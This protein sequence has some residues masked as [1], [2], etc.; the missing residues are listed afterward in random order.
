M[1]F[2]LDGTLANTIPMCIHAY[3]QTFEQLLGRPVLDE[4]ITVHFGLSDEG[5]IQRM[6]LGQAEAGWKLY[7]DVYE[8]LHADYREP[9]AGIPT[10][11]DLLKDRG[12]ALGVVT[13]KGAQ[14]AT[15]TL[16]YLGID[17]Y[18]EKVEAGNA[19]ANVKAMAIGKILA[20]WRM[21]PRDAAYVG[22]A[23]TDMQQAMTAGV[24]PLAACWAETATNHRLSS[25]SP[26]ATFESVHTFIDWLDEHIPMS[27][28]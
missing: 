8:K 28:H 13:G 12:V 21:G 7:L 20:A 23:D 6:V 11:L 25:M 19:H 16:K 18:F 3:R 22:D 15:L 27:I 5:I 1:L 10:A 26:F 17:H 2:D 24:L 9:F 14:T 4:E